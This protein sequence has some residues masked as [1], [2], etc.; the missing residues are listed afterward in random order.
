MFP[1]GVRVGYG[2]EGIEFLALGQVGEETDGHAARRAGGNLLGEAGQ[3]P[4][5]GCNVRPGKFVTQ[6]GEAFRPPVSHT[7]NQQPGQSQSQDE[8]SP[9]VPCPAE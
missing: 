6:R 1:F 4:V 8:A 2:G 5:V 3:K 9:G 7:P